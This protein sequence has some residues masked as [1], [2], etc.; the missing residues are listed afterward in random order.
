[1]IILIRYLQA[2]E[3]IVNKCLRVLGINIQLVQ[4]ILWTYFSQC[5]YFHVVS[6]IKIALTHF[7]QVTG[8]GLYHSYVI[9]SLYY[10]M[11]Q[12]WNQS[13][14]KSEI[15]HYFIRLTIFILLFDCDWWKWVNNHSL[16]W[17][18]QLIQL[19]ALY[20]HIEGNVAKLCTQH[21]SNLPKGMICCHKNLLQR[22]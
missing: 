10:A 8:F 6:L 14:V 2:I 5:L 21:H 20:T 7:S 17:W 4:D 12:N 19:S 18:A 13:L 9:N 22:S 15:R 1:M 11:L 3:A 16:F